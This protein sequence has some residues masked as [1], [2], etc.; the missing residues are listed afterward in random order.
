[1]LCQSF[2]TVSFSTSEPNGSFKPGD[3]VEHTTHGCGVILEHWGSDSG[4][5]EV[6]FSDKVR[7]VNGCRLVLV[8]SSPD[9]H[10]AAEKFPKLAPADYEALKASIVKHGLFEAIVLDSR[11]RVLDGRH[12]L[13]ACK[14]LGITPRTISFE[15]IRDA[16]PDQCLSEE[17]YVYDSNIERRHL[18]PSQKAAL[19]LQF[20]P[21][22]RK[23]AD[24][25]RRKAQIRGRVT[26]KANRSNGEAASGE[27]P[28]YSR[29]PTTNQLLA[30]KAGVGAVTMAQVIAVNDHAPELLPKIANGHLS[31]GDAIKLIPIEQNGTKSTRP[32]PFEKTVLSRW[33][34]FLRSFPKSQRKEICEII[35]ENLTTEAAGMQ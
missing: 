2:A 8:E 30:E 25:R 32:V 35:L 28:K 24:D 9:V 27:P 16:A 18:T 17:C 11:G 23:E 6:R 12:R 1:V 34:A 14:E 21:A 19:A 4:V 22:A 29:G 5:Y 26:Q 31:A 33:K 10:P 20:L 15:T 3:T 7:S 13:R